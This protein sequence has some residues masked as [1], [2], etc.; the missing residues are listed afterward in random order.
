M[1]SART[2]KLLHA[3]RVVQPRR[4]SFAIQVAGVPSLDRRGLVFV[5][6]F[7]RLVCAALTATATL[8]ACGRGRRRSR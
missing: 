5:T 4:S 3:V 2:P 7:C 1:S 8:G 6:C